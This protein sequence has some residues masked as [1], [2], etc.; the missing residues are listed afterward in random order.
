MDKNSSRERHTLFFTVVNPMN[1][2]HRDTH[3]L[4]FI[5]PRLASYEQKVEKTTTRSRNVELF[6]L[7]ET[8]PK[9]LCSHCLLHWIQGIVYCTRGQCLSDSESRRKCHKLRLDAFSISNYVI[10]KGPILGVRH[11]KTEVQREHHLA[12]NAWK[13][14]CKKVDA[15]GGLLQRYSFSISQ[16]SS[17]P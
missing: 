6:E 2:E 10:D 13:R 9:V 1:K 8:F 11:G 4:D 14:C 16:R 5:K 15:H 12:W 17:L 7:C 3:E